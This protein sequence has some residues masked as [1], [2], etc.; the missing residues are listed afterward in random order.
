MA[1]AITGTASTALT[2]SRSRS[3]RV[4]SGSVTAASSDAG[5]AGSVAV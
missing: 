4:G 5:G 2:T 1:S 3:G